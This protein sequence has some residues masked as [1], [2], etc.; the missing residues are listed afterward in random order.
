MSL[1]LLFPSTQR[2]EDASGPRQARVMEDGGGSRPRSN[3]DGP[4]DPESLYRVEFDRVWRNL[5]RLG[6]EEAALEDATQDVF[7]T[8]FRR[9]HTFDPERSTIQT[10]LF[11]IVIRVASRHR[12]G[13]ARRWA[14]LLPW[15]TRDTQSKVSER[16]GPAEQFAQREAVALLDRL[17][18]ELDPPKREMF[19]LI[20][21]EQL[22][23][24]EAAEAL[25]V[26]LNTAYWRLR[27]A[28]RAFQQSLNRL[29]AK[30]HFDERSATKE[31][32]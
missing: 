5:R 22:T 28:R 20:E 3:A 18:E 1:A 4:T 7:L 12:R 16:Q 25:D 11:G 8:V 19:L 21:V 30:E 13:Q 9:F 10:W 29:R 6:V 14:R 31:E 15:T 27:S 2:H 23:V 32:P 17:L 24:P 26:N